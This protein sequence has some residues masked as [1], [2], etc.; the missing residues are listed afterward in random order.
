LKY[1]PA[2]PHP[3]LG[4]CLS[5]WLVRIAHHNGLKAQTFCVN[6]FGHQRQIWNRDIDRL[7]PYFLL[8]WL[9]QKTGTRLYHTRQT[10][11]IPF[12]TRLFP[13]LNATGVLRWVL[14]LE[15]YH[16]KR[17]GYGMQYCPLCLAEDHEPYYRIYWRLALFTF[18]PKHRVSLHDRC[19]NCGADVAFHRIEL[20]KPQ[21]YEIETLDECWQCGVRLSQAPSEPIE[22]WHKTMFNMWSRILGTI[23]RLFV[24]SGPINYKRLAL[25]H[26]ICK[27]LSSH[28][29]NAKPLVVLFDIQSLILL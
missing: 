6:E 22:V 23:S 14:P 13:K 17:K 9:S 19:W 28:R 12:E 25:L 10:T 2:H 21:I 18:C 11:L 29:L 27:I 8:E 20:G 1:W 7:T 24:N 16:R 4:E 5:S 15:I 26:Q 3:L